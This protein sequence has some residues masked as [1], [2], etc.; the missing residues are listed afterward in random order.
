M[1][2]EL[3]N[4]LDIA[5]PDSYGYNK[6]DGFSHA[7]SVTKAEHRAIDCL[8]KEMREGFWEVQVD[9]HGNKKSILHED[10]RREA[11][12]AVKTFKNIMIADMSPEFR[13]KIKELEDKIK[14]NRDSFIKQQQEWYNSLSYPQKKKYI[15]DNMTYNN[16]FLY[17][18]LPYMHEYI[19]S[20]VDVYREIMEQ[21]ELC[22]LSVKYLKKQINVAGADKTED[23]TEAK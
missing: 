6:N 3:D 20:Q 10:T 17:E 7:M 9:K 21:L 12:E 13:K 8:G 16:N 19:S 23:G 4:P 18:K 22:L 5:E 2:Y 14:T 15:D 1:D 11:I